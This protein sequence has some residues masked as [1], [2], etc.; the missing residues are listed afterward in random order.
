M[1]A[2]ES[3]E[4]E[5]KS[6]CPFC[7]APIPEDLPEGTERGICYDISD[8]NHK[9][10]L[11]LECI[12]PHTYDLIRNIESIY[13]HISTSVGQIKQDVNKIEKHFKP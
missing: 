12:I 10:S 9:C 13:S 11:G 2:E 5:Y 6:K 3:L 7:Q 1:G 4:I 8:L